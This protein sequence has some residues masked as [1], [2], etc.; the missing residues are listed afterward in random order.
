M[1]YSSK[2]KTK[3][4]IR[5]IKFGVFEIFNNG[6]L[7]II[8]VKELSKKD[9]AWYYKVTITWHYTII[10]HEKKTKLLLNYLLLF[11]FLRMFKQ[12]MLYRVHGYEKI[13]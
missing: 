12:S 5:F 4:R 7:P 1:S 3:G 6:R 2:K 10:N 11:P 13:S 9:N 8:P